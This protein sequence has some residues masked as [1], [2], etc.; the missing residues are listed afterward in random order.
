MDGILAIY[1]LPIG[2]EG[3]FSSR[4]V[5]PGQQALAFYV[6]MRPCFHIF[7]SIFRRKR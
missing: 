2:I 1:L 3:R 5:S 6:A 7:V 4:V